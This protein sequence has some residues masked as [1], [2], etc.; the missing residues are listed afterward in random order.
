[1]G[2]RTSNHQIRPGGMP[3]IPH[4][5]L[6]WAGVSRGVGPTGTSMPRLHGRNSFSAPTRVSHSEKRGGKGRSTECSAAPDQIPFTNPPPNS[7]VKGRP[8]WED[9]QKAER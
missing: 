1:M 9:E 6:S 7:T 8:G 3:M 2:S 5:V 4:L